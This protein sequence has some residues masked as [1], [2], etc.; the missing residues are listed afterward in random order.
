VGS[1]LNNGAELNS[2][3]VEKH[4]GP[5]RLKSTCSSTARL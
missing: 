3:E 5:W 4:R 1:I 2:A